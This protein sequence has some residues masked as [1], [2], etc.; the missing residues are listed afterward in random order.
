MKKFTILLCATGLAVSVVL[1]VGSSASAQDNPM[2][3][4]NPMLQQNTSAESSFEAQAKAIDLAATKNSNDPIC[5]NIRAN[6][7]QELQKIVTKSESPQGMSLSQINK[8]S[9]NGR[10]TVSRLNRM[11]RNITG[12]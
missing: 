2:L 4:P 6:Y 1:A 7:D 3:Q 5:Q 11:N 10:G 12:N 9:Y 8:F